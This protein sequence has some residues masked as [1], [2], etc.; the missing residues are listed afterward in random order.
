MYKMPFM[1]FSAIS[2][3]TRGDEESLV[4]AVNGAE[5]YRDRDYHE[6]GSGWDEKVLDKD[7]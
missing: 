3:R 6:E 2:T 4:T 7:G 5:N 1:L